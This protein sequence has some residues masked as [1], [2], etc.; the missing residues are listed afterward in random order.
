MFTDASYRLVVNSLLSEPMPRTR[1]LPQGSPL[2]PI[3]FNFFINSLV[4]ELNRYN[5]SDIPHCL[6]Y[7]DDGALLAPNL[8][9][10]KHLLHIAERW[11][12]DNGMAY[13]VNKCGVLAIHHRSTKLTLD[14]QI[15]P[16]VDSYKYLGFPITRHGI[17]FVRHRDNLIDAA[18]HFLNYIVYQAIDWAP[19][20]SW[21]I[22]RTFV[23][24]QMEYG[25]PL[26]KVFADIQP[27]QD[28]F[29]PFQAIQDKAFAWILSS[30]SAHARL[31]EGILGALSISLRF[32]HLRCRY[33]FHIDRTFSENPL[34]RILYHAPSIIGNFTGHF[35]SDRLYDRFKQ[36][37][38]YT[39]LEP[40]E[41]S[42]KH[43]VMDALAQYLSSLHIEY[44]HSLTKDRRLLIYITNRTDALAD[45]VFSATPNFQKEFLA[46]RKGTLFLNCQCICGHRWTRRHL[47][48]SSLTKLSDKLENEFQLEKHKVGFH[49]TRLDYLLNSGKWDMAYDIIC[50]WKKLL[51]GR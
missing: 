22:Y 2:S 10:I 40:I 30:T 28:F 9:S 1:G 45:R 15:I 34:R 5:D 35:R 49:F 12:K 31:N 16:M 13:N 23:R 42:N 24:P 46:W 18:Q 33:Q 38:Y 26:L 25:G 44:L 43:K 32:T 8:D 27:N 51:H 39:T 21:A 7:A 6:F 47:E 14:G 50:E 3:I 29:A 37:Q 20:V 48:C 19:S 41:A 11:A 17:D 36:S 4:A